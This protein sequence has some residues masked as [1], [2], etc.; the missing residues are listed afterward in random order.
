MVLRGTDTFGFQGIDDAGDVKS[1]M[2]VDNRANSAQRQALVAFAKE[3]SGKAAENVLRVENAS[4][5]MSL[6]IGS[7]AGN[8]QA[9]EDVY[10]ATRKATPEDCICHNES[11]FYPPL[12][13]TTLMAAGVATDGGFRGQGLGTRWSIPDTR[14]AYMAVFNY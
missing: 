8:L 12:A 14:S 1:L 2:Y 10:L 7:L 11:A 5:D 9:G 4:I 3:H 13:E 6:D